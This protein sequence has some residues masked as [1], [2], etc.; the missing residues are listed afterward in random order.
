VCLAHRDFSV[1]EQLTIFYGV[2]ANCDLLVHNGFVFP[3]NQT[4]GLT[5]RLGVAKTDPLCAER[6]KLLTDLGINNQKY[7]V[8][9][10]EEPLDS[11]LVG[12]LRVLQMDQA[13]L[14]EYQNMEP[15]SKGKI[16]EIEVPTPFDAKMLQYMITR[17]ALLLRSY[18]TTLEE[19]QDLLKTNKDP[20]SLNNIQLRLCEKRILVAAVAYCESKLKLVQ[21]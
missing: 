20:V 5:L 6:T 19:D 12:F 7:F 4:D 1:G 21:N 13:A 10:T 17:C 16:M 14:E 11:K 18:K 3:D 9:R 2:R 8:R 15:E